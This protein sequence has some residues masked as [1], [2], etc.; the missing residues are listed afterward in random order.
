MT[1]LIEQF[2]KQFEELKNS[3]ENA[4]T[5]K[6]GEERR[7]RQAEE[8]QITFLI[9]TTLF[10]RKQCQNQIEIFGVFYNKSHGICL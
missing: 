2:K 6:T 7:K 1:D 10:L 3:L 4:L 8:V 5:P 9:D